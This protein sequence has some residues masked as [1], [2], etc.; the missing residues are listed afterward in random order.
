MVVPLAAILEMSVNIKYGL[1]RN[2]YGLL[3]N[4]VTQTY[5]M[6]VSRWYVLLLYC[7]KNT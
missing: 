1:K 6:T 5:E 3:E 2:I 4:L 7:I